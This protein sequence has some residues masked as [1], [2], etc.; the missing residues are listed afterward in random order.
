MSKAAEDAAKKAFLEARRASLARLDKMGATSAREVRTIL[1]DAQAEIAKILSGQPKDYQ[2]WRLTEINKEITR[3]LADVEKRL[4]NLSRGILDDGWEAGGSAAT[5]P[6][7]AGRKAAALAMGAA[8][9]VEI[10][11][12]LTQ[13]ST[14][15][16]GAMKNFTLG[17]MTG[18]SAEIRKKI[19][20]EIGAV[21]AGV[22]PISAAV[23]AVEGHVEGGRR[24][25]LRVVHT[26]LGTC[27]NTA[28][29]AR[30]ID[31]S[32]RVPGVKK[33]WRRSGKR[34]SRPT[35]DLADGQIVD[36][37]QPFMVGGEAL[38]CPCDPNGSAGNVINCGC[39]MK[40]WMEKWSQ[41]FPKGKPFTPAELDADP[42]K[43]MIQE[44]RDKIGG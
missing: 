39:R 7:D 36:V 25:A 22:R 16:L 9:P 34:K 10:A 42:G 3:A 14:S 19:Q 15:Q 11:A 38:M 33:Q 29:Q 13:V 37:D 1:Q 21:V 8:A 27:F 24:R 4:K 32:K 18:V 26:N 17:K 5:A 40:M 23:K 28:N 35:H 12:S 44:V 31:V 41:L 43:R 6:I 20:S 2:R 30:M